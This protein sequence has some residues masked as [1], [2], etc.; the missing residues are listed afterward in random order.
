MM[1][2]VTCLTGEALKGW[3]LGATVALG[4]GRKVL[5]VEHLKSQPLLKKCKDSW[6]DQEGRIQS[7][8]QAQL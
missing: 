4:H 5:L 8:R 1:Q 6:I 7:I 2:S 3:G